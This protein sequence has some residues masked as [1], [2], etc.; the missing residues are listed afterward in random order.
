MAATQRKRKPPLLGEFLRAHR[1]RLRPE[2]VGLPQRVRR[3]TPGLRREEVAQLCGISPTWYTWI[4]QGRTS[5][6]SA[7]TLDALA[8]GLHLGTAERAYLFEL[9]GRADP[10]RP[11]AAPADSLQLDGLVQAIRTPAYVLDQY[12]NAIA[13]NRPAA[14]L[15]S[16]W[17]GGTGK[18]RRGK[19][20]AV[21]APNLLRYVFLN[22]QARRFLM[23]WEERAWRLAAEYRADIPTLRDDP[24]RSALV[25]ELCAASAEFAAAWR[26]QQVLARDGGRRSFQ[27]PQGQRHY[28]QHILR[29]ARRPELRMTVLLPQRVAGPSP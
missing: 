27:G 8:Q 9:A 17:L 12:W 28:E 3:R 18:A 1:A 16:D 21:A 14:A 24:Q 10:V 25:E 13:W 26:S 29:V 2:E 20:P 7:Q 22:P 23:D 4:E 5:A 19:D 6:V 11:S 15:F